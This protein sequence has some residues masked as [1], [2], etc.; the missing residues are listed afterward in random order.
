VTFVLVL[1]LGESGGLGGRSFLLCSNHTCLFTSP[2][3][4]LLAF[5]IAS[6]TLPKSIIVC[7][8]GTFVFHHPTKQLPPIHPLYAHSHPLTSFLL[9]LLFVSSLLY[10]THIATAA[11]T[12]RGSNSHSHR[13]CYISDYISTSSSHREQL[14]PHSSRPPTLPPIDLPVASLFYDGYRGAY[15]WHLCPAQLLHRRRTELW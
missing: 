8:S 9:H 12:L 6:P 15:Q 5:R 3:N 4:T 7:E 10:R 2:T 11:A 14:D 1:V 13:A